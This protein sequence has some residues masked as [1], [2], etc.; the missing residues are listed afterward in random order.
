MYDSQSVSQSVSQRR[1]SRRRR[2]KEEEEE[3]RP[4]SSGR[5]TKSRTEG[6]CK[7]KIMR[8]IEDEVEE[9]GPRGEDGG[10]RNGGEGDEERNGGRGGREIGK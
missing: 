4:P 5:E 6:E 1:R 3:T 10:M 2:I 7:M 9:E 8:K